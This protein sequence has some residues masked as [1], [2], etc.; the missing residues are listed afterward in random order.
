MKTGKI[1][2][3]GATGST[4]GYA[5]EQLVKKGQEVRALATASTTAPDGSRITPWRLS[6]AT[7][8]T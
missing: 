6:P 3:T 1:L 4:G 5:I 2:I 8:S 7:T